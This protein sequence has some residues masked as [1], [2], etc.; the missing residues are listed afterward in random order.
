[1]LPDAAASL[2]EAEAA[3]ELWEYYSGKTLLPDQRLAVCVMMAQD[4]VGRWASSTTGREKPRQQ[5]KGD[6]VEV[7]E[8]WGLVQRAERILHTV[9]KLVPL[10]SQTQQRL[11]AV[12]EGHKD[13]RRLMARKTEGVGQQLIEMRNGGTIWYA[14]RTDGGGR[15]LD[16][17]SRLVIDEAQEATVEQVAASSGTMQACED[18][19]MNVL[20]TAGLRGKSAWWWQIRARALGADPGRFGYIGHTAERVEM[21]DDGVIVQHAVDP[22]DRALWRAVNPASAAG[23]GRGMEGL[24]EQF[25]ILGPDR[26]AEEHLCV[27][28]P[29][30]EEVSAGDKPITE[31]AWTAALAPSSKIHG[32]VV[33]GVDTGFDLERASIG[34]TGRRSDGLAQVELVE[35]GAGI[36]WVGERFAEL[37]GDHDVAATAVDA[38]GPAKAL[39]P[40]LE[41][42]CE[43]AG[44]PLVKLAAGT[45]AAG[46]KSFVAAVAER[47]VKHLGDQLLTDVAL[48]ATKRRM[49]D[50]WVWERRNSDVSPL[51][52]VTVA[53]AALAGRDTTAQRKSV[54]SERGLVVL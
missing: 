13:L 16:D 19:Q 24:E 26:F 11:L 34:V 53:H 21:G 3:I 6:E 7:V 31:P 44:V 1:M 50:G 29:P 49:G 10:A 4:A 39:V 40:T 41:R 36:G 15:G 38:S 5:G 12:I 45:Y 23:L 47:N 20:G 43:A 9:H 51:A 17:I 35:V 28:A 48:A 2:D 18:P 52:A 37:L 42:V 30:P 32:K 14:A 8:L 33:F 25:L 27:W 22:T 54:Y 46:C